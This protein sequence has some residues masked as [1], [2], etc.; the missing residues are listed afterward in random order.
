MGLRLRPTLNAE[1][2]QLASLLPLGGLVDNGERVPDERSLGTG[3][4]L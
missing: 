3:A 4:N 2:P 1:V